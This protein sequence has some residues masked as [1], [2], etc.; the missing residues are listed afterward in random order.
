MNGRMFILGYWLGESARYKVRLLGVAEPFSVH[1]AGTHWY[2][3]VKEYCNSIE[4]REK[5][6]PYKIHQKSWTTWISGI[7]G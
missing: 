3:G 2:L 4:A 1:T 5:A 6:H 7:E